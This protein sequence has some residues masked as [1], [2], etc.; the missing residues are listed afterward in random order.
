[1]APRAKNPDLRQR[2]AFEAARILVDQ[3]SHDFT[4]ARRKAA[5]R[6][7]CTDRRQLPDHT[8]IEL[9]LREYQRLFRN[10]RQS[11]E[12][13]RLRRLAE[14]AMEAMAIFSPRLV[15]PVL[16]GTADAHSKVQLHLFADAPEQIALFL[17]DR[18]I[19]HQLDENTLRYRGGTV[20][21]CPVYR[22]RAGETAMELTVFPSTGLRQSPL[23]PLDGQPQRRASLAQLREL[24]EKE[25]GS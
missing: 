1:M 7:G 21:N 25:D 18:H 12:L 2:I 3:G 17:M 11:A 23:G 9:A 10:E 16:E 19:P 20:Q 22:F 6:L 4:S 24:L 5:E 8:E 15:G 13:L 14:E